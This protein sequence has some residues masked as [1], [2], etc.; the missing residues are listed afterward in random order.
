MSDGRRGV[1]KESEELIRNYMKELRRELRGLPRH[2][3]RLFLEGVSTRVAAARSSLDSER[4]PDVRRVLE[5]MGH[6]ADVAAEAH[7]FAAR[8]VRATALEEG[9][10]IAL[11]PLFILLAVLL[12][13]ALLLGV[14]VG[15][16]LLWLS[17]AWTPGEKLIG[18]FLSVASY[19]WAGIGFNLEI[20]D[21]NAG[22][23]GI[24]LAFAMVAIF[25]L[26][27][28]LPAAIGV[29]YL[30]TK[31]RGRTR[32]STRRGGTD[33]AVASVG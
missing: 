4:E 7:D 9:A 24:F 18:V 15:A 11:S 31:L 33:M 8:P 3:K 22:T 2:R 20:N 5:Q 14:V 32:G 26:V 13:P 16:I 29:I 21:P 12:T 25:L 27:Q 30:W 10:L 6:P 28:M 23:M 17:R 1:S 19:V